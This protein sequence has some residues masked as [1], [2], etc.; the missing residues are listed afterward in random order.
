MSVCA[1]SA[2][3]SG[4]FIHEVGAGGYDRESWE[5]QWDDDPASIL[6]LLDRDQWVPLSIRVRAERAG[7]FTWAG[8]DALSTG[9]TS[10]GRAVLARAR[11]PAP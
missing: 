9:L 4:G 5:S 10:A 7:L 8:L 6:E 11:V 2:R 3:V 1:D